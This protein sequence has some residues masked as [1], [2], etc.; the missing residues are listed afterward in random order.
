MLNNKGLSLAELLVTSVIFIMLFASAFGAFVMARDICYS[1]MVENS[2]QK[3]VDFVLRRMIRGKKEGADIFGL[4]SARSFAVNAINDI[5]FTGTDGNTRR[6]YL[7]GSSIMYYTPV[8][9]PNTQTIY[10]GPNP[11]NI[12][13]RFSR[14]T[15]EQIDVYLCVSHQGARTITGSASTVVNVRNISR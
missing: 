6:F 10:T 1:K 5:S 13:L 14:V 12:D 8:P 3:D 4:R 2:L 11:G 15:S 7:S 9:T